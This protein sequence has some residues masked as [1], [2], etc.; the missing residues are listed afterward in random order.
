[1]KLIYPAIFH[2]EDNAYWV[3][4]PDLVGCQSFGDTFDETFQNS[5]EA[6]VGYCLSLLE[7]GKT[8]PIPSSIDQITVYEN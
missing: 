5:K 1:M 2:K 6:L 8:L 4:F 7:N 3:E